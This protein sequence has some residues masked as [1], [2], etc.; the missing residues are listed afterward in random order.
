M[1]LLL[2]L[3]YYPT[4]LACPIEIVKVI[5][6]SLMR[7]DAQHGVLL[8]KT[9]CLASCPTNRRFASKVPWRQKIIPEKPYIIAR[10]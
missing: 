8:R 10:L 2:G 7:Q 9:S 1:K 3:L 6:C 4:K 5:N